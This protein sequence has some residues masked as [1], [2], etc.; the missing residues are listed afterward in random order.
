MGNLYY[1]FSVESNAYC[2]EVYLRYILFFLFAV[3]GSFA[4]IYVFRSLG[5]YKLAKNSGIKNAGLVFVPFVWFYIAC[6]LVK[7]NKFFKSTIGKFS[8]LFTIIYSL[9]VVLPAL[10]NFFAYFP[11][12]GYYLNGGTI[13]FGEISSVMI[14]EYSLIEFWTGGVYVG[15][16]YVNPYGSLT[17]AIRIVAN[18]IV[19]VNNISEIAVVF[20]EIIVY[21][22]IFRKF[23]PN[24]YLLGTI[25]SM[26]GLFP[27]FVF[28]IRNNNA[29]DF[30]SYMRARYRENAARY[31][32]QNY[33][34]Q[35][36]NGYGGRYSSGHS[37][38]SESP[39]EE[40]NDKKADDEPFEEFNNDKPDDEPFDEFNDKK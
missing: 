19:I 20:V 30:E 26:F 14:E 40:F 25:F 9:S 37:S 39:F 15:I 23:W 5:L 2:Q 36:Y 24:H 1:Y 17:N 27:F 7:E 12:F 3:L 6:S 35:N 13:H 29:V 31:Y 11:L 33:G 4:V 22:A 38:D 32:G 28:G 16:D 21:S 34:N 8:I 10:Y 18:G